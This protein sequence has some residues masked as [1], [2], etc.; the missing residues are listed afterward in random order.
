MDSKGLP[1][2]LNAETLPSGGA[3]PVAVPK[4]SSLNVTPFAPSV[5]PP[6]PP[7]KLPP[8]PKPEQ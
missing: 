4:E 1:L 5:V 3:Q 7:M 2:V 8:A 6:R